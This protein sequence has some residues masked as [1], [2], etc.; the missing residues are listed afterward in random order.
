[1]LLQITIYYGKN[2][3]VIA[4]PAKQ[5]EA[6]QAQ[7]CGDLLG[8]FVATLLAMTALVGRFRFFRANKYANTKLNDYSSDGFQPLK[9]YGRDAVPTFPSFRYSVIPLFPAAS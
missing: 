2:T 4:R 7:P 5:D 9:L 8:C 3:F 1:M 6:T